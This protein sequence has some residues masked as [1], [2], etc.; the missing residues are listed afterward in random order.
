[1]QLRWSP[2]FSIV[3]RDQSK[4]YRNVER[5][6]RRPARIIILAHTVE[7]GEDS[8]HVNERGCLTISR[9]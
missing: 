8:I 6:Q 2:S 7:G 4:D 1:M 9:L 3:A 5:R